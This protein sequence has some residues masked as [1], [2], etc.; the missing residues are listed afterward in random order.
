MDLLPNFALAAAGAALFFLK[1]HFPQWVVT[2]IIVG[3]TSFFLV[4]FI[5]GY[6]FENAFFVLLGAIAL[7]DLVRRSRAPQARHRTR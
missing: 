1:D 2:A 6:G 3:C 4:R 5:L 7:T